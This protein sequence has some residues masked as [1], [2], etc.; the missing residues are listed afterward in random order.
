MVLFKKNL[1][2]EQMFSNCIERE[3]GMPY[4]LSASIDA[5]YACE[6]NLSQIERPF[7]VSTVSAGFPS[8]ADGSIDKTLDLNELLIR[9]PTA[10]FFVRVKGNS[11]RDAGILDGDLV[12]VERGEQPKNQDVV[13]AVVDGEFT[14]KRWVQSSQGVVLIAENPEYPNIDLAQFIDWEV[15][16]VVRYAIHSC[17]GRP[18]EDG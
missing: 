16:G 10:T 6:P 8:P 7:M 3:V 17:T 15:W 11:M 13:L 4:K 14:I 2:Y 1:K 12:V 18:V 5:L 9:Q